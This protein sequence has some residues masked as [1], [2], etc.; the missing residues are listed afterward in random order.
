MSTLPCDHCGMN[1]DCKL[2]DSVAGAHATQR[3]CIVALK[4]RVREMETD[5]EQVQVLCG[6]DYWPGLRLS[7]AV[8]RALSARPSLQIQLDHAKATL[9]AVMGA[10][11]K[12]LEEGLDGQWLAEMAQERKGRS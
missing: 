7:D 4:K 8:A 6:T 9:K 1:I 10:G 5:I 3:G 12:E 2:P 11:Q